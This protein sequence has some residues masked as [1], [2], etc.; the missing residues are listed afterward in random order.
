ML[1]CWVLGFNLNFGNFIWCAILLLNW[2]KWKWVNYSA[3]LV[4][5]RV[6]TVY[7]FWKSVGGPL[8][9]DLKRKSWWFGKSTIFDEFQ[10][11]FL[12]KRFTFNSENK[13]FKKFDLWK[14][15]YKIF[16]I[17]MHFVMYCKVIK[18]EIVVRNIRFYKGQESFSL[19]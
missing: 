2:E 9:I 7:E 1:I 13:I 17:L 4:E 16:F 11:D 8:E 6:C 5:S 10:N 12:W 3:F 15:T 19:F 18:D 14:T